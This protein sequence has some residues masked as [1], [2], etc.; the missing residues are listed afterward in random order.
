M[1]QKGSSSPIPIL[2]SVQARDF[3]L[4]QN[5]SDNNTYLDWLS[6]FQISSE[7]PLMEVLQSAMILLR[8]V[9]GIIFK[10]LS[11]HAGQPLLENFQ[12]TKIFTQSL[13]RI[14]NNKNKKRNANRG[15]S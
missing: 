1:T 15:F 8:V 6:T 12:T 7:K 2:E 13:Y 11:L 3:C 5:E 10:V 14:W 9:C 4:M